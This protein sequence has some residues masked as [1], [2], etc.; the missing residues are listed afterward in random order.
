MDYFRVLIMTGEVSILG[1]GR[2]KIVFQIFVPGPEI[3][4]S[5]NEARYQHIIVQ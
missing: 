2:R 4:V 5:F 1:R 3:L